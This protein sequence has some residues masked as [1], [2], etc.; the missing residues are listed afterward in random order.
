[1]VMA[2]NHKPRI[3]TVDDAIRR[4]V[5]M[6]LF[7][8]KP[9]NVNTKL[10]E[11]LRA[12]YPSILRWMIEGAV[13]WWNGGDSR[14]PKPKVI[15]AATEAYFLEQA[16]LA[17]WID[18][19]CYVSDVYLEIQEEFKH[20]YESWCSAN[21]MKP[22]SKIRFSKELQKIPELKKVDRLLH[23]RTGVPQ[24]GKPGFTGIC[25]RERPKVEPTDPGV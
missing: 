25:L 5:L 4:R 13:R 7:M 20:L 8:F 9:E 18:E 21:S 1:M 22:T 14:L 19:C 3:K 11:Q 16:T 10:K 23:P 6:A 12:E 15:T 24:V 2:G 17:D